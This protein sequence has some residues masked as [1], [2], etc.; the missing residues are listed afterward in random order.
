MIL[1]YMHKIVQYASDIKTSQKMRCHLYENLDR[2]RFSDPI[3]LT[4]KLVIR[5]K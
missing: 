1:T 2:E 3:S 5:G 4:L